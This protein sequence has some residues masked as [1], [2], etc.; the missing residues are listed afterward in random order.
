MS[1]LIQGVYTDLNGVSTLLPIA[2]DATGRLLGTGGGGGSG[3]TATSPTDIATGINA[4]TIVNAIKTSLVSIDGKTVAG[5]TSADV[6]AAIN[7]AVDVDTLISGINAIRDRLVV[8][9]AKLQ[10]GYRAAATIQRS[11][12]TITYAANDVYGAPFELT[13]IGLSGGF[14]LL[15]G[16]RIIF[17]IAALPVGMGGFSLYLYTITPPSA[18]ADNGAFSVP[19]GDRATLITPTGVDLGYAVLATGGGSV[20]LNAPNINEQFKLAAG[21]TSLFGYLVTRGAFTPAAANETASLVALAL[22]V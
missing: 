4:A 13:N 6:V 7:S 17:N 22:G 9:E 5:I 18:V 3:G 10:S 21:G 15:S 19:A 2:V 14:I 12:D 1:E 11:A 16:V 20:V 8:V